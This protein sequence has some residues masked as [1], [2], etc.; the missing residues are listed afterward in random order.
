MLKQA[1]PKILVV[2]DEE[3]LRYTIETFLSR[4]GYEVD[5][6]G[7]YKEGLVKLSGMQFDLILTDIMLGDGM[8][9]DILQEVNRRNLLCPVILITGH[10]NIETASDAV[11]DGAHDYVAKPVRKDVLL[12]KVEMTLRHK[13]II[14]ENREYQ[15]TLDA[16]FR[17]VKDA[18]V[19]VDKELIVLETNDAVKDI[20][21]FL[22]EEIK[23]KP[24]NSLQLHSPRP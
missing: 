15:S 3:A 21:G 12:Q 19:T 7:S 14:D 20:C 23:G 4:E 22:P 13:E 8:G 1:K 11:R 9:I 17:S 5:T 18:I 6:A 16:I 10:P 24:F 2:D